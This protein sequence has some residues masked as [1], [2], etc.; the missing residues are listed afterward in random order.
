MKTP[1]LTKLSKAMFEHYN[2]LTED[3]LTKLDKECKSVTTTNCG[4][5]EYAIADMFRHSVDAHV[6]NRN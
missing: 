6:K 2:K 3:E 4:W 1:I 5:S